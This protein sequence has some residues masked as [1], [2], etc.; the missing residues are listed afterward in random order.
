[1]PARAASLAPLTAHPRMTFVSLNVGG[2]AR[3]RGKTYPKS[4]RT[5][6]N[7]IRKRGLGL[8]LGQRDVGKTDRRRFRDVLRNGLGTDG[9]SYPMSLPQREVRSRLL[10]GQDRSWLESS[11]LPIPTRT[12][13]A[14]FINFAVT[15]PSVWKVHVLVQQSKLPTMFGS[16][17][18]PVFRTSFG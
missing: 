13:G 14:F 1:M 18:S 15:V 5:L 10:A 16:H 9:E 3:A 4:L 17:C 8:G 6:G 11:S 12:T 7:R 2:N